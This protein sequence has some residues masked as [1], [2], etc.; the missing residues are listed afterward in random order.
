[1]QERS[2]LEC[3]QKRKSVKERKRKRPFEKMKVVSSAF[4]S[5]VR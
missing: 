4:V 1:M 2:R 3:S 5:Q